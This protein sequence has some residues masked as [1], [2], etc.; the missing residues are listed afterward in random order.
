MDKNKVISFLKR[1]FNGCYNEE[2]G[3]GEH[4][5]DYTSCEEVVK[6]AKELELNDLVEELEPRLEEL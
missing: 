4:F 3:G 6:V 2:M 5:C 1:V